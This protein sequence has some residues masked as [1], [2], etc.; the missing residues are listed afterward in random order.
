VEVADIIVS[1]DS[2]S[3]LPFSQVKG[4]MKVAISD[5]DMARLVVVCNQFEKLPGVQFRPHPKID[6]KAWTSD[7][8]LCLKDKTKPFPV[9]SENATGAF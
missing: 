7:G 2:P 9:G 6:A 1:L 4:E 5:P 3:V 8:H